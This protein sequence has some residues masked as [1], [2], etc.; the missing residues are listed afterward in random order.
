[1]H[2]VCVV[3]STFIGYDLDPVIKKELKER[4]LLE[5]LEKE[6]GTPHVVENDATERKYLL[7][8]KYSYRSKKMKQRRRK[9]RR[10]TFDHSSK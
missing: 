3:S 5:A 6:F 8:K 2:T 10:K 7:C 1:M 4:G 9:T